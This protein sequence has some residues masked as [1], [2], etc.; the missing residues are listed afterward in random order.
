MGKVYLTNNE[1][2]VK[3][4]NNLIYE[5]ES[6]ETYDCQNYFTINLVLVAGYDYINADYTDAQGYVSAKNFIDD[7]QTETETYY[8]IEESIVECLESNG[9]EILKKLPTIH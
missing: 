8:Y 5:T 1:V 6:I 3:T 2:Y 4:S 7:V 9:Y